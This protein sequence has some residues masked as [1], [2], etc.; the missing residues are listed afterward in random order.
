MIGKKGWPIELHPLPA[1]D[2]P[3]IV[4]LVVLDDAKYDEIENDYDV[5]PVEEPDSV[6]VK[7]YRAWSGGSPETTTE[8]VIA[9]SNDGQFILNTWFDLFGKK[10]DYS[11]S[12][13]FCVYA[14][15]KNGK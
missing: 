10:E 15:P 7:I 2:F 4:E 9:H 5:I 3:V 11:F 13:G 12:F 6:L 1:D 14:E 8:I